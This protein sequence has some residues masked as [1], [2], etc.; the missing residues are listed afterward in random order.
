V[1]VRSAKP[2]SSLSLLRDELRALFRDM[3]EVPGL[4]RPG[5][6]PPAV[7]VIETPATIEIRI[8]LLDV[9]PDKL[10]VGIEGDMLAV[11]GARRIQA[12]EKAGHARLADDRVRHFSRRI[13]IPRDLRV[14]DLTASYK[15]GLLEIT[16]IRLT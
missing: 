7:D 9:A 5:A 14:R 13:Q 10:S 12:E 2:L 15:H 4:G 8:D 3:N 11:R 16:L 1:P 6:S